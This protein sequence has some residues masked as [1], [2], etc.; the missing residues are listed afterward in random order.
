MQYSDT[1]LTWANFVNKNIEVNCIWT[2]VAYTFKG[3]KLQFYIQIQIQ[4]QIYTDTDLFI[5][6]MQHRL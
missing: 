3:Y 2:R 5:S 1:D 4:I 6:H